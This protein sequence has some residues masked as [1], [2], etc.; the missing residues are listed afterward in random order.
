MESREYRLMIYF[1]VTTI[2]MY[3]DGLKIH[4]TMNSRDFY[5][6]N[7]EVMDR[8]FQEGLNIMNYELSYRQIN[9]AC[10]VYMK[11]ELEPQN[12]KNTP[13]FGYGFRRNPTL[14]R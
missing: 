12:V 10:I 5:E 6:A 2:H 14:I 1:A 3:S 4:K 11:N 8:V 9:K 13:P 7:I